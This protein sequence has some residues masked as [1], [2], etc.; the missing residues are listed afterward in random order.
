MKKIICF[1]VVFLLS[2]IV[3]FCANYNIEHFYVDASILDNGDMTVKELIVLK[4][5]F[6][7]YERD[8][9]YKNGYTNTNYN[10]SNITDISVA[11]FKV[12][13][14]SLEDLDKNYVLS[15]EV[16]TAENGESNKYVKS[17][18]DGGYRLRMYHKTE[19][20]KT[21]FL[22]KYTIKDLGIMHNDCT[23]FYWNFFGNDFEDKIKGIKIKINLPGN[24]DEN[25]FNWWFHGD[26]TGNSSLVESNEILATLNSLNAYSPI[27]FRIL[28]PNSAFNNVLKTDPENVK[29]NIIKSEDEIVAN[30]LANIKI[31]RTIYYTFVGLCIAFYVIL[32]ITWI[33]V[34]LKFDK[35]RKPK[36]QNKYNRE[37]ID[38]YNVEV[39]DYLFHHNIT[40]NAM[41]ASIM[42]LIYKKNISAEKI[43]GTKNDYKFT[44]VNEENLTNT[45]KTLVEFLFTKVGA[46]NVFSTKD[47]KKYASGTKTCDQFMSSYTKWK[48]EVIKD[49]ESQGF[50]DHLNGKIM[51]ASIIMILAFIIYFVGIVVY[52]VE[53]F[54][55]HTVIILAIAFI[56]YVGFI[57]RKSEKGIEDYA[58][59][60][61]FKNFLNDFGAFDIKELPEIAL[62]ERYLVYATIFGLADK[63]EKSMNVKIKELDLTDMAY[64][65]D[66]YIYNHIDV[67][68]SINSSIHSAVNSAQMTINSNNANASGGSFGGHGGG[69]SSGGGFGGG[70]GGGRGF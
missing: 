42:N 7:G 27:D 23:E 13:N 11:S 28:L 65:N 70:G 60:Q 17:T 21:A 49:G 45:E 29:E 66:I 19:S 39:I 53:L 22:I 24:F 30:D 1:L 43:E 32:I 51:Y 3:G 69:F 56:I 14:V 55:L 64:S 57:K 40:P 37:F 5:T 20:A 4:G 34:Y 36:F 59:W 54:M 6:N 58:K 62:W 8:I 52:R 18:L 12:S 68:P 63:V 15:Q 2:P 38:D 33:Y 31:V 48:N 61:G 9:L 41:S 35:E 10:A 47:L 16:M 50:Y 26:I 44:L 67:A 25:D 46:N